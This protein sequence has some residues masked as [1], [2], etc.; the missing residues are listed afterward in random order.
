MSD[1][2][3]KC[4]FRLHTITIVCDLS[5]ISSYLHLQ[6]WIHPGAPVSLVFLANQLFDDISSKMPEQK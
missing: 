4:C 2:L 6:G 5:R 1:A 3:L